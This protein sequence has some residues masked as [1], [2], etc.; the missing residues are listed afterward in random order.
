[1]L[2]QIVDSSG[3]NVLL[4]RVSGNY[5]LAEAETRIKEEYQSAKEKEDNLDYDEF[6]I[7]DEV[8]ENLPKGFTRV[9]TEIMICELF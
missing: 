9:Y 7:H 3:E 1:M 4:Y 2:I 8:E 6:Y 5:T